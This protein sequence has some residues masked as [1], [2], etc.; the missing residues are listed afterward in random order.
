MR[1]VA[2]DI[3]F[4][5][6]DQLELRRIVRAFLGRHVDEASVR[7]QMETA[8]GFDRSTWDR[9][10]AELGLPAL[11]IPED[12][13]GIGATA[14]EVVVVAEELGA[15]L[16][17]Q[18]FLPA[19]L[20]AAGLVALDRASSDSLL[21]GIVCGE[22]VAV[23]PPRT[24]VGDPPGGQELR[25]EG[26]GTARRLSGHAHFVVNGAQADRFLVYTDAPDG[27]A[28]LT[29]ASG[30]RVRVQEWPCLDTTRPQASLIVDGVPV[31]VLASGVPV[32]AAWARAQRWGVLTLAAGEVGVA[33]RCLEMS[34]EYAGVREQFGRLIGS[35]QSIKHHCTDMLIALDLA[36]VAVRDAAVSVRDERSDADAAVHQARYLA[37]QAAELATRDCIQVHGGIG[38]T[39]EHP[40]HL[41]FKRARADASLLGSS[42][43]QLDAFAALTLQPPSGSRI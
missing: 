18:P 13:E 9:M 33:R 40:A 23:V 15:V 3:T 29:F 24:A 19:V 16:A 11:A 41:Y 2:G 17:P 42:R 21:Q 12:R 43:D 4:L 25:V 34:V 5:E 6:E 14:L 31:T 36:R 20:A 26:T 27:P 1:E 32:A 30:E 28:L 8:E 22:I 38:F 10:T 35:Q 37:Q 39:W 7:R